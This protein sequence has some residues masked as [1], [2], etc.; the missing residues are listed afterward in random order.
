MSSII[1]F[2]RL[3]IVKKVDLETPL[4]VL[5]E[6]LDS[7]RVGYQKGVIHRKHRESLIAHILEL[8]EI[9]LRKPFSQHG[10]RTLVTYINV[11]REQKWTQDLLITAFEFLQQFTREGGLLD[12][13][14]KDIICG[15]QT[16]QNPQKLNACVLY[17]I[18]KDHDIALTP[19]TT[20][21]RMKQAVYFLYQGPD[22]VF[23]YLATFSQNLD[24]TGIINSLVMGEIDECQFE[25][26]EPITHESLYNYVQTSPITTNCISTDT[27]NKFAKRIL[28][29]SKCEAVGMAAIIYKKDI[30]VSKYP[31]SEFRTLNCSPRR[32]IPL[33]KKL[34]EIF[35]LNP[36]LMDLSVSFN[37]LF[38]EQYYKT[39]DLVN[40]ARNEGYSFD[41]IALSN[42]YE[43]LQ[44]SFLLDNFYY[45]LYP[46]IV[47]EETPIAWDEVENL[48][49]GMIVCYGV[50]RERLTAFNIEELV[51]HFD[52]IKT[53]AHPTDSHNTLTPRS[54]EKLKLIASTRTGSETTQTIK[55]RLLEVIEEVEFLSN[56]AL[57][58]ARQ[59]Y[60][61]Y[62]SSSA[63]QQEDIRRA[64]RE[65]LELAMYMRGWLGPG[66]DYPI[67]EAPVDDQFAVNIRVTE[68]LSNLEDTCVRLGE[69][70]EEILKLP[71]LKYQ[72]EF[73][74][75][76]SATD[77]YT[78]GDRIDIVRQGDDT[79]N[80]SSCIRLSSNLFAA[81]AYRYLLLIKEPQP[82]PIEELRY[83]S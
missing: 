68:S 70:G 44:V 36:M 57:G 51:E 20:I 1:S 13:L 24:F 72:G 43:L 10:L 29:V 64:I 73:N 5:E 31:I 81:T 6:I 14:P 34:H 15:P 55:M 9:R 33:D 27:E 26:D 16:P 83:I 22:M 58:K 2:S 52:R 39:Q 71:L 62:R 80:I 75:T 18:C 41:R 65:L 37:P 42:P 21:N 11:E 53:F 76:R 82:F 7:H 54:I 45:G 30:S 79:S 46:E 40:M 17:R 32:Y 77:G 56:E 4:C 3:N 50:R 63:A 61:I 19:S 38:P 47:N 35:L 66:H 74:P 59:F 49:P 8:T 48:E 60:Q 78:I 28:P 12:L 25:S 69:V 67:R 23:R